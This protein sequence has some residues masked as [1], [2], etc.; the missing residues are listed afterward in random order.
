MKKIAI[1]FIIVFSTSCKTSNYSLVGSYERKGKDFTYLLILRKDSTFIYSEQY[2]P[3]LSRCDGKWSS[4][5]NDSLML[6]CY[7]VHSLAKFS[8]GYMGQ[9]DHK[10]KVLNK[11]K[12]K[13]GK[14][15]LK[16]LK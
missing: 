16:K 14:F 4:K 11:R 12:L 13:M 10:I 5:G 15:V 7:D 6:E 2:Q 9:R 8:V 1:L 3:Y